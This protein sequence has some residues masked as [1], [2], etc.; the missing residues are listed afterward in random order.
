VLQLVDPDAAGEKVNTALRA[1]FELAVV[2]FFEC[3]EA[4]WS[5][6]EIIHADPRW[7]VVRRSESSFC[8]GA[9]PS[10]WSAGATFDRRT[11]E[12]VE[13][14]GWIGTEEAFPEALAAKIARRVL[15][16]GGVRE[17]DEDCR[18]AWEHEGYYDVWPTA[19]GL[20]FLPAFPHVIQACQD[21][22]ELPLSDV[23]P[24]LNDA[25]RAALF[26]AAGKP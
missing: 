11:G 19:K 17:G 7:L 25:G 3:E 12:I 5:M 9:H 6:D 8:G 16:P 15:E 22:V 13:A 21:E 4:L 14:R 10:W 24:F 20:T 2:D 18:D 26:P 23:E 1:Q